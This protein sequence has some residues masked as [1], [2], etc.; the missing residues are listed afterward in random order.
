VRPQEEWRRRD[1]EH[2]V[3]GELGGAAGDCRLRGIEVRGLGVHECAAL[4][5]HVGFIDTDMK[6]GVDLVKVSPEHV[7][8]ET[9][10]GIEAG[11]EEILADEVT[12]AVKR[13]RSAEAGVY[14]EGPVL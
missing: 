2:A 11:A 12:R 3:G 1:R 10:D 14:L 4:G 13:G 6:K 7:A 5:L 9:V 8:K